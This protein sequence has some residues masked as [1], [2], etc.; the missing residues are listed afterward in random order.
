MILPYI[1][2]F[3]LVVGVPIALSFILYLVIKKKS[4]NKNL[5]LIALLPIV[6]VAILAYTALYPNEAFYLE[7]FERTIGEPLPENV[8]FTY[9]TATYPDLHGDYTSIAVINVGNNFYQSI[10]EILAKKGFEI[11]GE[12]LGSKEYSNALKQENPLEISE[13]YILKEDDK[14]SRVGMFNDGQT[15]FFLRMSW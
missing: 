4:R 15:I 9:K 14:Y 3:V 11:N 13:E 10:P 8:S 2:F 1:V 5:R 6:I 7:E 12:L